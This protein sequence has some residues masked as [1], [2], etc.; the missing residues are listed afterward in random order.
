VLLGISWR[1]SV[2]RKQEHVRTQ[3]PGMHTSIG[4]PI[5]SPCSVPTRAG[6]RCHQSL[7]FICSTGIFARRLDWPWKPWRAS[8]LIRSLESHLMVAAV[9]CPLSQLLFRYFLGS[10][11]EIKTKRWTWVIAKKRDR[12]SFSCVGYVCQVFSFRGLSS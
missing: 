9:I 8:K 12:S 11:Q 3:G 2:L 6:I 5:L 4:F 1:S 7:P 10:I